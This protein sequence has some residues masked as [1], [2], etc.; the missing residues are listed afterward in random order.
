MQQFQVFPQN[1]RRS[2]QLTAQ[3]VSQQDSR[4][5]SLHRWQ[6]HHNSRMSESH[7]LPIQDRAWCSV[8]EMFRIQ[9]GRWPP[10]LHRY[11]C[12]LQS[13]ERPQIGPVFRHPDLGRRHRNLRR[14]HSCL[15]WLRLCSDLRME[16][17]RPLLRKETRG[18]QRCRSSA[19]HHRVQQPSQQRHRKTVGCHQPQQKSQQELRIHTCRRNT[20]QAMD[21]PIPR[22]VTCLQLLP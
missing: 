22:Q 4:Q 12:S 1:Y 7:F 9:L 19:E 3:A 6:H 2:L 13:T 14:V 16:G 15:V 17:L 5:Y 8:G 18:I 11:R 20:R 10:Q 21:L